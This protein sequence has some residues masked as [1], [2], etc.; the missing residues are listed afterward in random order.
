MNNI[1][2]WLE[3]RIAQLEERLLDFQGHANHAAALSGQLTAYKQILEY[4]ENHDKET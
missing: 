1:C 4:I 3:K 2:K